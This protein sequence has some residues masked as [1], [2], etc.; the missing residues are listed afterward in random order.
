MIVGRVK[1]SGARDSAEGLANPRY[2]RARVWKET[3]LTESGLASDSIEVIS[4]HG[5]N[6][7]DA[8]SQASRKRVLRG[9]I[10]WVYA[11]EEE[12]NSVP[13]RM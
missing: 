6:S 13:L 4:K 9:I 1:R 8:I 11:I 10:S 12:L 7:F 2:S 5:A 3:L